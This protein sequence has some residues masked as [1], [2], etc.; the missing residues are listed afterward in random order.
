ME[1]DFKQE[2][3]STTSEKVSEVDKGIKEITK[4][5]ISI[6]ERIEEIEKFKQGR[7]SQQTNS[8]NRM[9]YLRLI[10]TSQK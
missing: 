4:N 3:I 10:N 2:K 6:N 7:H 5:I 9:R 8:Q 1:D